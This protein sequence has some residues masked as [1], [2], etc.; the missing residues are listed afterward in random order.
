[1]IPIALKIRCNNVL[2][3]VLKFNLESMFTPEYLTLLLWCNTVLFNVTF[4]IRKSFAK[5]GDND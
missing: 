3:W 2:M 5:L 4:N 1:M